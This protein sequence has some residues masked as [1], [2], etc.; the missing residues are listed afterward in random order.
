MGT[1]AVHKKDMSSPQDVRN[2]GSH[3]HPVKDLPVIF[4]GGWHFSYI[5]GIDMVHNKLINAP[6]LQLERSHVSFDKSVN[7]GLLETGKDP[8]GYRVNNVWRSTPIDFTFPKYIQDNQ[9][10]LAPFIKEFTK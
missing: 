1:R 4:N 3:R 7:K 6:D 8:I 2:F 9:K 10:L 5:G